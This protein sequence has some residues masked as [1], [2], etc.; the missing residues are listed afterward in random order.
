MAFVPAND[1]KIGDI[2]IFE[3]V[4]KCKLCVHIFRD[5]KGGLVESVPSNKDVSF[6]DDD[7]S[8]NKTVKCSKSLKN[9]DL[10]Q[11]TQSEACDEKT[12]IIEI[13]PIYWVLQ[14]K[15]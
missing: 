12:G 9:F 14:L 15:F 5:G 11:P 3:L 7:A 10:G 6:K 1:I 4:C 8:P 2:C 13:V